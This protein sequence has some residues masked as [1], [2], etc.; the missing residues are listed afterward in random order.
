MSTISRVFS[1]Q[2]WNLAPLLILIVRHFRMIRAA[3]VNT[4]TQ[5]I[6]TERASLRSPVYTP[7]DATSGFLGV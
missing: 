5:S 3:D 2:L 7:E 6:N 1:L 4:D